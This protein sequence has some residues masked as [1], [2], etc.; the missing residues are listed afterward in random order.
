MPP[1]QC[2][3]QAGPAATAAQLLHKLVPLHPTQPKQMTCEQMGAQTGTVDS[4]L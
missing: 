3:A 1:T 4:H 2:P